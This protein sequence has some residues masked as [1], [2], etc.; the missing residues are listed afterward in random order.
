MR[1]HA[2]LSVAI[3]YISQLENQNKQS[4][5]DYENQRLK[6]AELEAKMHE[7][8]Q[9]M[10]S[11]QQPQSSFP[12]P[13]NVMPQSPLGYGSHYNNHIDAANEPAR[14]LPPIINNNTMQGIQYSEDRR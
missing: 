3:D 9:Q 10:R 2:D 8:S 4:R 1:M 6:I 5:S 12:P 13:P 11:I 14:T 7:M